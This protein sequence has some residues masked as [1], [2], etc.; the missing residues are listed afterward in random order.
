M[1]YYVYELIEASTGKVFYVGKG[2]GSRMY[3]HKVDALNPKYRYRRSLHCKI[4]S[5]YSKGEE[6][7]Y[8]KMDCETEHEAYELEKYLIAEYGRKDLGLGTLCNLTDGGEGAP[9]LTEESKKLRADKHRG[10]KRSLESR[11]LMK[12]RQLELA[13]ERRA[14]TGYGRSEISRHNQSRTTKGRI[15]SEKARSAKRHNPKQVMVEIRDLKNEVCCLASSI[16][17]AAK[18]VQCSVSAIRNI[19][20]GYVKGT[21]IKGFRFRFQVPGTNTWHDQIMKEG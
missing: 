3:Q 18:F 11:Q 16:P 1:K 12:T 8:K 4:Q 21:A 13:A 9:K 19:L 10:L 5:L 20:R 15:W 14:L 2:S 17:E 6:F 7:W